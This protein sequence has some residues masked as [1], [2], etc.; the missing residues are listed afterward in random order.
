MAWF[1][2]QAETDKVVVRNINSIQDVYAKGKV[3][4]TIGQYI[5]YLENYAK[6]Y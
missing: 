5:I 4:Y 6:L 1:K 3:E 2:V